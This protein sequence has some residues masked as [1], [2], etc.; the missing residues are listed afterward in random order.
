[1]EKPTHWTI[2]I[3]QSSFSLFHVFEHLRVHLSHLYHLL[4]DLGS[5]VI[6]E[7]WSFGWSLLLILTLGAGPL[8]VFILIRMGTFVFLLAEFLIVQFLKQSLWTPIV[9]SLQYLVPRNPLQKTPVSTDTLSDPHLHHH[10]HHELVWC[11]STHV[12][13]MDSG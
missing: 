6:Y 12:L 9:G 7:F 4:H 13:R 1:M 11:T 3:F 5:L 8:L 2:L 10:L